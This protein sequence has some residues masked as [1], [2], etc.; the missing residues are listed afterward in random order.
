M[1]DSD[2]VTLDANEVAEL[3]SIASQSA[4]DKSIAQRW[5]LWG[6]LVVVIGTA[7]NV[8]YN[9]IK[10]RGAEETAASYE[11]KAE[12][13][14]IEANSTKA[15]DNGAAI[16]AVDAKAD[17]NAVSIRDLERLIVEHDDIAM[18]KLDAISRRA[19]AIPRGPKMK[20]ARQRFGLPGSP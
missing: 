12:A 11:A 4:S 17:A 7:T 16:E 20:A 8:G 6:P 15:K 1:P 19:A 5:K 2:T 18:Q 10:D 13:A 9:A 3:R 14:R